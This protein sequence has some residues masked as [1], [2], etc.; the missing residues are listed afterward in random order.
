M[1]CPSARSAPSEAKSLFRISLSHAFRLPFMSF[2]C[3]STFSARLHSHPC[4]PISVVVLAPVSR[5]NG[6]GFPFTI[7]K[8]EQQSHPCGTNLPTVYALNP[9][10]SPRTGL[11]TSFLSPTETT[12]GTRP[13]TSSPSIPSPSLRSPS[14]TVAS[15]PPN[16][17][18]EIDI[19]SAWTRMLVL[20]LR[21]EAKLDMP[22]RSASLR[23]KASRP[24]ARTANGVSK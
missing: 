23:C 20:L 13:I 19:E 21:I 16:S 11:N 10:R 2:T 17:T 3:T 9:F 4:S 22:A 18:P 24:N 7:P 6:S 1:P 12:V 8:N 5:T 15:S 14:I